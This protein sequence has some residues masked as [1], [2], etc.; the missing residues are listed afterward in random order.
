MCLNSTQNELHIQM[1]KQKTT[2]LINLAQRHFPIVCVR[3]RNCEMKGEE[4]RRVNIYIS[5]MLL[6]SYQEHQ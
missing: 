3:A 1:Q 2:S 5:C 4:R 6:F